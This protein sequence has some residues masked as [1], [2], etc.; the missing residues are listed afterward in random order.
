VKSYKG[1]KKIYGSI[2]QM[3]NCRIPRIFFL[4]EIRFPRNSGRIKKRNLLQQKRNSMNPWDEK[5]GYSG[6]LCKI[7]ESFLG[8]QLTFLD[9]F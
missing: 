7:I 8:D 5:K 6:N 2:P 3:I 9:F 4:K 1:S